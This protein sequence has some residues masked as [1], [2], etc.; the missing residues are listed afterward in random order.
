MKLLHW[1]LKFTT[2]SHSRRSS[3]ARSL[4]LFGKLR[5]NGSC[6]IPRTRFK[7]TPRRPS[8]HVPS[9]QSHTIIKMTLYFRRFKIRNPLKPHSKGYLE[10]ILAAEAAERKK[11]KKAAKKEEAQRVRSSLHIYLSLFKT[12]ASQSKT[13]ANLEGRKNT[14]RRAFD[15]VRSA[16]RYVRFCLYSLQERAQETHQ[17]EAESEG[18]EESES[19]EEW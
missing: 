5:T 19:E 2:H 16:P 13:F 9:R 11:E 17:E 10:A 6:P 14:W 15:W 8:A 4:F 12:N 7:A 18:V 3:S 1:Q